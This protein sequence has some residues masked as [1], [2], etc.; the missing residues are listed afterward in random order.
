[1]KYSPLVSKLPL[2]PLYGII[3]NTIVVRSSS[4]NLS[5]SFIYWNV[6]NV[7][8]VFDSS[9]KLV[10]NP[11]KHKK[12]KIRQRKCNILWSMLLCSGFQ[13]SDYHSLLL[14][15][16]DH[17]FHLFSLLDVF[18]GFLGENCQFP[19]VLRL[20]VCFSFLHLANAVLMNPM[21]WERKRVRE[22]VVAR[23]GSQGVVGFCKFHDIIDSSLLILFFPYLVLY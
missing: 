16:A 3:F 8:A 6:Q 4:K 14:T 5:W 17:L 19:V 10:L 1:M 22:E 9:I 11:S 20:V 15:V 7:K 18:F 12:P 23:F 21:F 2:L 13:T